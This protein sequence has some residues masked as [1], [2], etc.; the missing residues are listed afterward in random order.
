MLALSYSTFIG[1]GRARQWR[2]VHV[3]RKRP[4]ETGATGP[5]HIINIHKTAMTTAG[6]VDSLTNRLSRQQPSFMLSFNSLRSPTL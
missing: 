1:Q 2:Q 6:S 3:D 4:F 5:K